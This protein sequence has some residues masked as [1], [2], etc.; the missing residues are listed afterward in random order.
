MPKRGSGTAIGHHGEILQCVQEVAGRLHRVL[1][2]L[3]CGILRSTAVFVPRRAH[4]LTVDP[5]WKVKALR[6][7]ELTLE[8]C[9]PRRS[10]WITVRSNIPPCW[11]LGSSTADVT[12]VIRAVAAAFGRMLSPE[13]IGDLAVRS[14]YASDS[15]M[16]EDCAVV[17]AH[18]EGLVLERLDGHL[19][20]L[21]VLGFNTD[22]TQ[23]GVDTLRFDRARYSSWE[24]EAFRPLLG[25][26]RHAVHVQDSSLLG[27]VASASARMNQRFLP[28]PHFDQL[29]TIAET[30]GAVGL[31]VAHSGSVAGILFE[32]R[33]AELD[34]RVRS[35]QALLRELGCETTWRFR[36]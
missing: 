18:R 16:C 29:E 7:A 27:L 26:L 15:V 24:V 13:E 23:M 19:P 35:G 17:F 2:S 12:A 31:Q 33:T 14:E 21:E 22:P 1:V 32:P 36:T 8:R 9:G 20:P 3:P 6:A 11:G 28:K 4:G 25:L 10:G 30:T 5:P 34:E